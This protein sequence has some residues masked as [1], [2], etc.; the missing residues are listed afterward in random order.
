MMIHYEL[1]NHFASYI[2]T[3]QFQI[4]SGLEFSEKVLA[5]NFAL[6]EAEDN[7]SGQNVH[8]ITN[9]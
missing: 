8:Y 2:N 7:T 6:S 4:S 3:I 1:F 5:N 9:I